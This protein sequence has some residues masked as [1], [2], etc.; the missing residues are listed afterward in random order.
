MI[1]EI[2]LRCLFFLA[3]TL[4]IVVGSPV[5]AANELPR[6]ASSYSTDAAP[7]ISLGRSPVK[8][9]ISMA[10]QNAVDD[11]LARAL[12][13][14]VTRILTASQLSG[15][16][17]FIVGNLLAPSPDPY[18]STFKIIGETDHDSI[19]TVAVESSF[20]TQ[21]LKDFFREHSIIPSAEHLPA[22][23]LLISE[24]RPGDI[25]PKYW[26]GSNPPPHDYITEKV[27]AAILAE[28]GF[29]VQGGENNT[30]SPE[31]AGIYFTSVHDAEASA[32][33]GRKLNS[34]MVV[35]GTAWAEE[36][37]NVMGDEKAYRGNVELDIYSSRDG[38]RLASLSKDA[39]A[40]SSDPRE[41]IEKSL[42]MTGEAAGEELIRLL[43]ST[44]SA[45][46]GDIKVIKAKIE[47]TDYLSSFIM[48]RKTLGTMNDIEDV[49]TRELSSKQA[50]VDISFR[51]TG[52]TMAK[53]LMLKS[54]DNFGLELS[55]VT[56][57]SLTIKFIPKSD[58]RTIEDSDMEGAFI[59]E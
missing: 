42:A 53:A 58:I 28:H 13:I 52:H 50:I 34:D 51:G 36:D 29:R 24:K 56:E 31:K 15:G 20:K 17:G 59:S 1:K 3:L 55:D 39:V 8:G 23:L 11:A 7:I 16:F 54:F 49:Q 33:L 10:R 5:R 12:E 47:G 40:A 22:V 35:M 38:L 6:P 46:G 26:W 32:A 25:Q 41:G 43:K 9:D 44:W 57:D 4:F 48:L 14:E 37:A 21:R 45:K 18:I 2:D 30:S 27:V 19:Y